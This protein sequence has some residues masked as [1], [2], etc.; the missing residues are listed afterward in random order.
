MGRPRKETT[1]AA[2]A[3]ALDSGLITKLATAGQAEL[4]ALDA[5]I[6]EHKAKRDAIDTK[7]RACA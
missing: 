1:V 7:S 5:A 2:A 4:D 3:P 6:G